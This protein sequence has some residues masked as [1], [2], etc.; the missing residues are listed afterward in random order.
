MATPK[1]PLP[2]L[3][4]R[5]WYIARMKNNLLRELREIGAHTT[6]DALETCLR[7]MED[8]DRRVVQAPHQ[9]VN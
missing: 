1:K 3:P 4:P 8:E 2:D 5:D 7:F 6:A 9:L